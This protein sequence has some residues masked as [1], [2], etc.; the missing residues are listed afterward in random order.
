MEYNVNIKEYEGPMDLLVDLIKKNEIDIYDIPIHTITTQFLD[1]INQ[2]KILNMEITSDFILMASTL[3]EIKSKMLLPLYKFED[4]ELVEDT[5]DPRKELV[6]KILEYN[7]YKQISKSLK[8]SVEYENKTFYKF[9][10]DFSEIDELDLLK[11]L[12]VDSLYKAFRN[13]ILSK[14]SKEEEIDIELEKFSTKDASNEILSRLEAGN[15]YFSN[16]LEKNF[17]VSRTI[18]YFLSLLELIK[19]NAVLARQTNNFSD[20]EIIRRPAS[21]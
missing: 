5:E 21:E 4:D 3:I 6:E 13:I 7:R 2:S 14:K 16:L 1:Y 9:Q 12:D 19:L 11:N 10:E 20:I 18:V 8:E 15:L 17:T